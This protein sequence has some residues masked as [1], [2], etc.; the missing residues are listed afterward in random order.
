MLFRTRLWI[1]FCPHKKNWQPVLSEESLLGS[2]SLSVWI[3][4][5]LNEARAELKW[6]E[7]ARDGQTEL[8]E[9][10]TAGRGRACGRPLS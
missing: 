6:E 10:R 4:G 3:L 7:L 9:R 8:R 2:V 1:Q 5:L